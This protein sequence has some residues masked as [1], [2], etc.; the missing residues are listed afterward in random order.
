MIDL[1]N[2]QLANAA[3]K[4]WDVLVRIAREKKSIYYKDLASEIGVDRRQIGGPLAL[5]YVHCNKTKS[6]F[7]NENLPPLTV[8]AVS[9][10]DIPCAKD[11]LYKDKNTGESKCT[12]CKELVRRRGHPSVGYS[13]VRDSVPVDSYA[14]FQHEH[15]AEEPKPNFK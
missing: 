1:T 2:T 10:K 13:E 14:V 15:W 7:T 9:A 12:K 3:N 4:A 5:I 6:A 11:V 8:L